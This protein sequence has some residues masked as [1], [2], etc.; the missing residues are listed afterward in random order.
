MSKPTVPVPVGSVF[1]RLTTIDEP[2]VVPTKN[3]LER[4]VR[5]QCSCGSKPIDVMVRKVRDGTTKGCGCLRRENPGRTI[6]IT[7]K[8]VAVG[9]KFGYWEVVGQPFLKRRGPGQSAYIPCRCACGKAS[10]VLRYSLQAG[11]SSGCIGCSTRQGRTRVTS[12]GAWLGGPWRK[13]TNGYLFVTIPR[14][15][16]HSRP[17]YQHVLVME[18]KEGRALRLGE[19]VHHKNGVR[20]DN[21]PENLEL[22]V[23]SQPSGQRPED[24][25]VWAREILERYGPEV[26]AA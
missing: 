11:R 14:P 18:Q 19:N 6:S 1:G 2:F 4:K 15:E 9:D 7:D 24:L 20:Q 8:E 3:G 22:W 26:L 21:R 25:V 13:D 12:T 16:G 17:L 5:V 10:D 23:T